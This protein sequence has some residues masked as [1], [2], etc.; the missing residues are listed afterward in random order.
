MF[1]GAIAHVAEG[2]AP[3]RER[4]SRETHARRDEVAP[5]FS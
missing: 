1:S 5:P 2:G 3:E 4:A